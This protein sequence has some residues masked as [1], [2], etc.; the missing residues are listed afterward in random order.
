VR[1][2]GIDLAWGSGSDTVLAN[3]T[4]LVAADPV[5]RIVD[6]GWARGVDEILSR[7]ETG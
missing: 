2:L 4:G 1:V 5:G 7:M 6:A 3:E